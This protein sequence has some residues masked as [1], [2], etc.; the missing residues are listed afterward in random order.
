M[1]ESLKAPDPCKENYRQRRKRRAFKDK[2]AMSPE[3]K[4]HKHCQ[5]LLPVRATFAI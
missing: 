5:N 3:L 1:S 4:H 2:R